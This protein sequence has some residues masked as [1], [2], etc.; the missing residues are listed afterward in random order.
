MQQVCKKQAQG[1][2]VAKE[3]IK[4]RRWIRFKKTSNTNCIHN[5][6]WKDK[7]KLFCFNKCNTI[8]KR[9]L[10]Y[11]HNIKT[12]AKSIIIF[13]SSFVFCFCKK[14]TK[15]EPLPPAPDTT[16]PIITLKGDSV[17]TIFLNSKYSD[18]GVTATD[19][20][21]GDISSKIAITGSVNVDSVG[22]YYFHYSVKDSSGNKSAARRTIKV[23]NQVDYLD[24][25]YNVT[26]QIQSN[27]Y[28][29][30]SWY[31]TFTAQFISSQYQNNYFTITKFCTHLSGNQALRFIVTTFPL[32]YSSDYFSICGQAHPKGIINP[33]NSMI[34]TASRYF[35]TSPESYTV[36]STFT[37]MKN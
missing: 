28:C 32:I 21:D 15:K 16:S 35:T 24:G 9:I 3:V 31:S 34:I 10:R 4:E 22:S 23:R 13:S 33:E 29:N 27:S 14:E 37:R 26:S 18:P 20:H 12:F 7:I 2:Y 36:T 17:Q 6:I 19:N 11:H 8:F 5:L 25:N 1:S 30:M